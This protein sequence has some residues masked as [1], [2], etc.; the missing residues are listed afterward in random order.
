MTRSEELLLQ[1]FRGMSEEAK[2]HAAQY[3]RALRRRCPAVTSPV[4]ASPALRL[5]ADNTAKRVSARRVAR[6]GGG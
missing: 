2:S 6:F 1:D 4:K 3:M 5:V